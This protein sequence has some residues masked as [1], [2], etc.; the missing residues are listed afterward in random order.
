MSSSS[1]DDKY[2]ED[3]PLSNSNDGYETL[4]VLELEKQSSKDCLVA[5]GSPKAAR[6]PRKGRRRLV[7]RFHHLQR[8]IKLKKEGSIHDG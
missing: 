1:S 4:A 6:S 8:E 7:S 2:I 3:Q 5:K